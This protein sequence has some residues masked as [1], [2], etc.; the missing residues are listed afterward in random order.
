MRI[1]LD[2]F[3]DIERDEAFNWSLRQKRHRRRQ[4]TFLKALLALVLVL[5][6]VGLIGFLTLK[7]FIGPIIKTVDGLPSDFPQDISIY[8]SEQAVINLENPNGRAKVISGLQAMPD[9]MLTMFLNFLSEDLKKKLADNFGDNININKNFS[10]DDLKK[11]I[12]EVDFH[13]TNTVNLSWNGLDKTKEEL[14]A[15]YKQKLQASHF[16]FKENLSDYQ[17]NLGFWKDDVFGIM[18]FTDKKTNIDG[19]VKYNSDVDI[20][21]NYLNELKP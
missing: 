10:V 17:I 3:Q 19:G 14:A 9:W 12:S 18:S 15:Y 4:P 11:A 8:Q 16:E 7:F 5:L 20:T 13:Q 2:N 1:D 6:I 21:V